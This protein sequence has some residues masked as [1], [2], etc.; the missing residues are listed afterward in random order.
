M[1]STAALVAIGIVVLLVVLLIL[2]VIWVLTPSAPSGT[3][4]SGNAVQNA[5]NT[6]LTTAA[7]QAAAN[8]TAPTGSTTPAGV[9]PPGATV[10]VQ[11]AP[12][13][14]AQAQQ[15]NV[16]TTVTPVQAPT[17]TAVPGGVPLTQKGTDTPVPPPTSTT[18]AGG[19]AVNA[20]DVTYPTQTYTMF[21]GYDSPGNTIAT[22]N[23]PGMVCGTTA[24][25]VGYN[26]NGDLKSVILPAAQWVP[27][28]NGTLVDGNGPVSQMAWNRKCGAS[29]NGGLYIG[30]GSPYTATQAYAGSPPYVMGPTC[31]FGQAERLRNMRRPDRKYMEYFMDVPYQTV[32]LNEYGT[33][34]VAIS[35]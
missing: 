31:A 19:A 2:L 33:P 32:E 11:S 4:N 17:G 6:A 29:N 22:V 7:A 8:I 35:W 12:V 16:M 20:N 1:P 23:S 3:D 13:T 26:S 25:C 34:R 15:G 21:A 9:P 5:V 30:S 24:G 18:T 27:I 28:T 10:V 14:L